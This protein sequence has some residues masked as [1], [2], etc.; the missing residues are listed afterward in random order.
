MKRYVSNWAQ[1]EGSIVE[2]YILN[3]YI[4]NWS[5]YIDEIKTKH[6]RRKKNEDF[7]ESSE[8]LIVARPTGGKQNDGDLSR[9]LLNTV[10]WS[11]LYNSLELK[12]YLKYVISNAYIVWSIFEYCLQCLAENKSPYF[13][14]WTQK[15][16]A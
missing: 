1:L 5:L 6:N 4:N 12:P 9:A 13:E 7:G 8:G 2:A 16:I 11:L 15:Y 3:E 14:Q 10:Y